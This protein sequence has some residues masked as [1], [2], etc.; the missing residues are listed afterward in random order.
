MTGGSG[1]TRDRYSDRSLDFGISL[2]CVFLEHEGMSSP[3]QKTEIENELDGLRYIIYYN[4]NRELGF[5]F[6]E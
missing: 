6:K 1:K 4:S 5:M 3:D 2:S